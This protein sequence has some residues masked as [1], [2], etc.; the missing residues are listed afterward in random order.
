MFAAFNLPLKPFGKF[1]CLPLKVLFS[2]TH[3]FRGI[4]SYPC[5]DYYKSC[6]FANEVLKPLSISCIHR[7]S[8][9]PFGTQRVH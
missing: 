7:C 3:N 5:K 8:S 4:V 2:I 1:P 6:L 9:L